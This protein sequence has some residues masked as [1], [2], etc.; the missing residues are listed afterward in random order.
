MPGSTI[1][2][3]NDYLLWI[4]APGAAETALEYIQGQGTCTKT[5]SQAKIDTGSKTTGGYSTSAP[6]LKDITLDLD[7]IVTLPDAG[8]Y[9]LLETQSNAIPNVPFPVEIR[10]NG[11]AGVAADA[12]FSASMYGTITSTAFTQNDKVAVKVQF[13]LAAAPTVNTLA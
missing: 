4:G 12:V 13:L 11:Q 9:T 1:L 5:Q 3:G 8:G 6:G 10:K 7:I 2:L